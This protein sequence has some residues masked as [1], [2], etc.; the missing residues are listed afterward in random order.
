M[1]VL[2]RSEGE[3]VLI[4][5]T[6]SPLG[7]VKVISIRTDRVRLGFEFPD[8]VGVNRKE[9]VDVAK[10]TREIG[11]WRDAASPCKCA[12]CSRNVAEDERVLV[13]ELG[14]TKAINCRR[15]GELLTGGMA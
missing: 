13:V 11:T 4:G 3:E 12:G 5:P 14:G 9:L 10:Q 15:C 6:G 8:S 1:L 2:T 7:S